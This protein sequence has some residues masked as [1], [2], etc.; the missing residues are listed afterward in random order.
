[1]TATRYTRMESPI[2]ELLLVEQGGCLRQIR[3]LG[4]FPGE[5]EAGWVEDRS[6]LAQ[7]SAELEAYFAGELRDFELALDPSGTDFQRR[8]WSELRRI[9]W[10]ETISYGELA[11]RVGR[12]SASRAVGAA[13]GQNPLPIVI[14]C[15]RVIGNDGDLTGYAGKRVELKQR[16]LAVEGIQAQPA[17]RHDFKVH[18]ESMY[19]LM[20]GEVE[21]CLP[22]CGSLAERPISELTLFGTRE[23][24]EAAGFAPC[25][26]C[27]PDL[28][29]LPA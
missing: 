25:S 13:N 28:H 26:S 11:R 15:H 21:Y 3:F 9:P 14:P 10:G 22:T 24:A 7:A 17:G 12:P 1:M 18:R 6:A 16:L 29:P 23:R 19:T 20:N 5:P 8:V 4:V 2:G 27:R